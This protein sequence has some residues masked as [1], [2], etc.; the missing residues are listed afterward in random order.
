MKEEGDFLYCPGA[1]DDTAC[2]VALIM[3]AIH[4]IKNR[5]NTRNGILFVCN[6]CEEG[7]GNLDGTRALFKNYGERIETFTSFDASMEKGFVNTAVGSERYVIRV[8]TPGGHSFANFGNKNAIAILSQIINKLYRQKVASG[9][10]TTYNVGT[11][12]GGTSI[13]TIAQAAEC[14]YE[15][16]SVSYES[17]A[18][19]RK[20]FEDIIS[21]SRAEG[22]DVSYEC[23]GMRPCSVDV[24]NTYLENIAKK[25]LEKYG[26]KSKPAIGST[27][28]NIPL[29]L[30]VP[31]V[32]FGLII[33]KGAHTRE[34]YI[35]LKSY[36]TGLNLG[37][38]YILEVTQAP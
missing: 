5:P 8:K 22:N 12:S 34:E 6:S 24:D 36:S 1:G 20:S 31:A 37:Y 11:I 28:C 29:S 32:C 3:Y 23:V 19:M 18:K 38:E 13:N 21:Q 35:D 25:L 7:L 33:L 30:G 4:F 9:S 10:C 27:D 16:R 14:T 17:L 2:F 26:L 15:Y